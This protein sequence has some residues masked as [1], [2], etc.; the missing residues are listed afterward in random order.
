MAEVGQ[1]TIGDAIITRD[2]AG[3]VTFITTGGVDPVF[4]ARQS[5]EL[6]KFLETSSR[7]AKAEA[8]RQDEATAE[9]AE[10]LAADEEGVPVKAEVDAG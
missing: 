6:V 8:K 5:G 10:R 2:H 4:N 9:A 1:V 3:T 7:H